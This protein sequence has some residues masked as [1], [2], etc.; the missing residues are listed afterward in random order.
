MFP[1]VIPGSYSAITTASYQ[2]N[3]LQYHVLSLFLFNRTVKEI[4]PRLFVFPWES[5]FIEWGGINKIILSVIQREKI[6]LH[7]PSY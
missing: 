2:I 5:T 7:T 6:I 4:L 3:Y 1:A